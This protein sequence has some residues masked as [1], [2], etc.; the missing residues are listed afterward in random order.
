[1]ASR[2]RRSLLTGAAWSVPVAALSAATPAAAASP[3][4][5]TVLDTVKAATLVNVLTTQAV[6][7][8]GR[9]PLAMAGV[10]GIDARGTDLNIFQP[11]YTV[12]V[13]AATL[14][15]SNGTTYSGT[16]LATGTGVLNLIGALP[17]TLVFS[18]IAFPRGVYTGTSN[19]VR[20]TRFSV[21][22]DMILVSL[23]DLVTRTYPVTLAWNLNVFG[24][25]T[26]VGLSDALG[27]GTINYSGAV[28]PIL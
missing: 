8:N 7:V 10:F 13:T 5:P 9:G 20:P 18:N 2:G 3:T 16:G 6:V 28:L 15:M 4:I 26:V 27:V 17:G 22:A 11:A 21:K 14:T 24:I 25:G 19:P 1:M 23:R 12:K